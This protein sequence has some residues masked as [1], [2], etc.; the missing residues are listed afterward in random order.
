[1]ELALSEF[2]VAKTVYGMLSTGLIEIS[3]SDV[4]AAA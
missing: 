1:M 3:H 2:E 4:E